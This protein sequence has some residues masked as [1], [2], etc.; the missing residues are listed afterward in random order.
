MVEALL[1]KGEIFEKSQ[2]VPY[3]GF[4]DGRVAERLKA[5]P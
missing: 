2:L 5:L 4:S 3:I 1:N